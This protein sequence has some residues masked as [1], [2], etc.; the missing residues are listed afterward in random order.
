MKAKKQ[1][2]AWSPEDIHLVMTST[3]KMSKV[4]KKLNRTAHACSMKKY[5]LN[6]KI[7]AEKLAKVKTVRTKRKTTIGSA[8]PVL[9]KPVLKSY[10]Y[11]GRHNIITVNKLGWLTRIL[12]GVKEAA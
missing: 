6:K 1:N 12:L 3:L 11:E 5:S 2:Q 8:M 7:A 4:A 10:S 9:A